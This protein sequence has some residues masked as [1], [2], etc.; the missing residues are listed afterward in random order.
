VAIILAPNELHKLYQYMYYKML[1]LLGVNRS[2]GKEWGAL[3]ERYQGL[4]LP[5]FEV[6]AFSK[7]VHFLQRKWGGKDSISEMTSAT[8][9]AFMVEVGVY[10]NILSRSWK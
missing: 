9:E 6:H 1:P 3:T 8:Y 7:K 4:G 5:N 2:I 10:G